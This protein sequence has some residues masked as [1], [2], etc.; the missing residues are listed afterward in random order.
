MEASRVRQIL[1]ASLIIGTLLLTIFP[2]DPQMSTEVIFDDEVSQLRKSDGVG[3]Q[4][5]ESLVMRITHD[6]GG[7]L[8]YPVSRVQE[9][10]QIE[11]EANTGDNPAIAWHTDSTTLDR[12]Q[13][14]FALWED[15][16]ASRNRSLADATGWNDVLQPLM[17]DGWC[18]KNATDAE[19]FAFEG[20]VLLL[21][22][23]ADLGVACPSMP[24]QYAHQPPS[25]NELLWM[26]WIGENQSATNWSE[27][28]VWAEQL[29]ESTNFTFEAIGV[30]M[31]FAKSKDLAQSELKAVII[32]L[33][34]L[35]MFA[36]CVGL[37][38]PLI[39]VVTIGSAALV[40]GA[41]MGI[42][43]MFGYTI[44]VFDGIAIPIIMGV[45]VDGA[46]WYCRSSHSVEVVRKMLFVAM[47][48]T[49]AAVSLALFSPLRA[50]RSLAFIMVLGIFLDWLV[51]RYLL[52]DFYIARKKM[53]ANDLPARDTLHKPIFTVLW[54]ALLL[55]LASVALVSPSGVEVLDIEQ[56]LPADDPALEELRQMQDEYILASSTDTW[57]L[58]EVEGDSP[59]EY[60]KVLAFQEQLKSHPSII[61]LD[62]GISQSKLM[63]GIPSS[64]HINATVDEVFINSS[65]D[66]FLVNDNR[67]QSDGKTYGILIVVYLDGQNTDAALAFNNDVRDLFEEMNISGNIGGNL[68]VGA[69]LAHSFDQSRV[70][71]IFGAGVAIFIVGLF[72]LRSPEKALRIAVGTVAVGAAVD[73]LASIMGGRG[74]A[75]APAVLLGMGFAADYLSHS[76]STNHIP[77][78]SDHAARWWSAF[79]SMCVFILIAFTAFPPASEMGRLLALSI[80]FSVLLATA[81]S[82]YQSESD[83]EE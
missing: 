34:I 75:S 33:A 42:L 8:M 82:L 25:S 79:S 18:G 40:I 55:L 59:E 20:S 56:F 37:R 62:T 48:T 52:E 39:A 15:A 54:P 71:Q 68:A 46:F 1:L 74:V 7:S 64:Q 9:L 17:E 29:T 36:L 24:G 26:V 66:S 31:L 14:P 43:S 70:T 51:T 77:T 44:S 63:I 83:E 4:S 32:P 78:S 50:Q 21:P 12:I 81:L 35:L 30:N 16:F 58:V 5:S 60:R 80:L 28:N 13:T 38:D 2:V 27:L 3:T 23:E 72:G 47:L 19:S 61:S 6:D 41:E 45:A 11:N 67:L 49:I 73:G 22:N 69:E 65:I 10:L 76:S 53:I 57:I